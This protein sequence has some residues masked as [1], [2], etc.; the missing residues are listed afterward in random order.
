MSTL[1][2]FKSILLVD[3][4]DKLFCSLADIINQKIKPIHYKLEIETNIVS[5]LTYITT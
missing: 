3:L 2:D 4:G 5:M 1:E